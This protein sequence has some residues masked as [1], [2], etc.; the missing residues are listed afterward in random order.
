MSDD[1]TP[2]P[3]APL[4]ALPAP[5]APDDPTV[6]AAPA[7]KRTSTPDPNRPR[8]TPMLEASFAPVDRKSAQSYEASEAA[9]ANLTSTGEKLDE[10]RAKLE[11]G[12]I[13]VQLILSDTTVHQIVRRAP[14]SPA[15]PPK[16]EPDK[17]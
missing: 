9:M 6:P 12:S 13:E 8:L 4:P 2:P 15:A 14:P 17:P 16:T 10:V 3:P 11:D 5:D 7:F 1:P